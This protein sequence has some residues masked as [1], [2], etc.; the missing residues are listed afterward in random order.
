M[1]NILVCGRIKQGKT[2][3]AIFLA[4]EHSPGVIVW[5]PRHMQ[6]GF[7]VEPPVGDNLEEAIKEKK[8]RD[9]PIVIWPGRDLESEFEEVCKVLFDPPERFAG[10]GKGNGGFAFV[11]DEAADLQTSN[12]INDSLRVAVKQHPRSVVV[13]QCTHSLQEWNRSSKD[14]MSALYCFRL[15]GR[16]L[17]Y[18]VRYADVEDEE[19]FEASLKTLP[20]H[21]YVHVDF[22]STPGAPAFITCAPLPPQ[23]VK[24]I[25]QGRK[26]KFLDERKEEMVY[27]PS[28]RTEEQGERRRSGSMV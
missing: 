5:D 26:P 28:G 4:H 14:T 8:Y 9:A 23:A 3:L 22:E 18:V 2:T 25:Q 12:S 19:E 13:I 17:E 1:S 7:I 24:A 15:Q 16:S 6:Q 20:E 21:T 11:V 10:D 27:G